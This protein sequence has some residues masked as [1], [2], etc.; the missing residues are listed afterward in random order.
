MV[1]CESL[2]EVGGCLGEV[3]AR[4]WEPVGELPQGVESRVGSIG[5]PGQG[6]QEWGGG[7]GLGSDL[8]RCWH[9]GVR[10][11]KAQL[12]EQRGKRAAQG[13]VGYGPRGHGQQLSGLGLGSTGQEAIGQV[14]VGQQ[15]AAGEALSEPVRTKTVPHAAIGRGIQRG[16]PAV[17]AVATVLALISK[18]RNLGEQP[19][20]LLPVARSE[21]ECG[22]QSISESVHGERRM[23]G[24]R[25]G[26]VLPVPPFVA[27]QSVFHT[28]SRS[29]TCRD[30]GWLGCVEKVGQG[31][32]VQGQSRAHALPVDRRC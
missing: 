30:I 10:V 26:G 5:N 27:Q 28:R 9:Q 20:S 24:P 13:W 12:G 2:S 16:D 11:A 14:G 18:P 23:K 22:N 7:F 17:H 4:V 21:Q 15:V 3:V 31:G 25:D 32:H 19:V 8:D 1:V 29:A 6:V